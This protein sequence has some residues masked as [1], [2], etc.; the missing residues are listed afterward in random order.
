MITHLKLDTA[1]LVSAAPFAEP[2]ANIA[3]ICEHGVNRKHPM[4]TDWHIQN[5]LNER[6]QQIRL[7]VW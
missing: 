3:D 2:F 5:S 6:K 1:Q 4:I 7:L